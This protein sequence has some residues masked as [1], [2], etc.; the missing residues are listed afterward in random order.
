M[1][2]KLSYPTALASG[3]AFVAKAAAMSTTLK[4]YDVTLTVPPTAK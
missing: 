2:S 4:K 3:N 1:S